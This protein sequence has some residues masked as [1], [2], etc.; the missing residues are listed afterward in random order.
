VEENDSSQADEL[1]AAMS[2]DPLAT[3]PSS[4]F[5]PSTDVESKMPG[6]SWAR[7]LDIF[8]ILY[9]LRQQAC[10]TFR[11]RVV[12]LVKSM[13]SVVKLLREKFLHQDVWHQMIMIKAILLDQGLSDQ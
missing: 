1:P 11:R 12:A 9:F 4:S 3:A 8:L 5:E 7:V 2:E 10:Q 6:W 13:D